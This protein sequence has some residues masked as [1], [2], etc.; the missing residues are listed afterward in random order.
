MAKIRRPWGPLLR[1][2]SRPTS[3]APAR[4]VDEIRAGPLWGGDHPAWATDLLEERGISDREMLEFILRCGRHQD[5]DRFARLVLAGAGPLPS[6]LVAQYV[7]RDPYAVISVL[8]NPQLADDGKQFAWDKLQQVVQRTLDRLVQRAR[9]EDG[10]ERT[11]KPD[12]EQHLLLLL[13]RGHPATESDRGRPLVVP[14]TQAR[15]LTRRITD[16]FDG[17]G[18]RFEVGQELASSWVLDFLICS[19]W[20]MTT[21]ELLAVARALDGLIDVSELCLLAARFGATA[22]H[23]QVLDDH[24][25]AMREVVGYVFDSMFNRTTLPGG[26]VWDLAL[27]RRLQGDPDLRHHFVGTLAMRCASR[28][29]RI[30]TLTQ[31]LRFPQEVGF[32]R[33]RLLELAVDQIGGGCSDRSAGGSALETLATDIYAVLGDEAFLGFS[34]AQI[35]GFLSADRPEIRQ[36]AFKA[37]A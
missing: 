36:A 25:P 12:M 3:G 1:R 21:R 27:A 31:L 35:A 13:L 28:D 32:D 11:Q 24:C 17:T 5:V 33:S 7:E 4:V 8:R 16:T 23:W 19:D 15:Q 2:F 6:R 20:E 22:R 37:L 29:S 10:G 34:E 18:L 14:E 9:G 26:S 30:V